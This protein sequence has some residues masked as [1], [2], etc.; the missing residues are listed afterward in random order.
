MRKA[1]NVML[2]AVLAIGLASG[3]QAA[4]RAG[5]GLEWSWVPV[6]PLGGFNMEISGQEFTLA[7]DVSDRFSVGVFRGDGQYRAGY[8]Y[9]AGGLT[10]ELAVHAPTSVSGLRLLSV[11][12]VL[13]DMISLGLELGAVEFGD[14]S[15]NYNLTVSDGSAAAGTEFGSYSSVGIDNSTSPLLGIMGKVK[16][17]EAKASTVTTA[18]T[19][20]AGIRIVPLVQDTDLVGTQEALSAP[21]E[22]IDPVTNYTNIAVQVGVG[23]WF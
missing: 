23:L 19:V 4:G 15:G 21:T 22:L 9:S 20:A 2:G 8:D 12:P 7:W 13:N 5:V 18:V 1:I 10:Y 3:A 17:I 6:M 11:L 14:G 16:L